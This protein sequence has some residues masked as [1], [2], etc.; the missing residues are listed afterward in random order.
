MNRGTVISGV[1]VLAI[2]A[3]GCQPAESGGR[4]GDAKGALP[5]RTSEITGELLG[6]AEISQRLKET[7]EC[8]E[9]QGLVV[10]YD[11]RGGL[12]S[13]TQ[14]AEQGDLWTSLYGECGEAAGLFDPLT[15]SELGELYRLELENHACLREHGYPS[16]E[17]PT[18]QSFIDRWLAG[19]E[20]YQS[21]AIVADHPDPE[22][23][24]DATQLC[25]APLWSLG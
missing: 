22:V 3:V 15:E 13:E 8:M 6:T 24:F 9:A 12:M 21:I 2:V 25:P 4:S 20:P 11:G 5:Q 19:D 14:T 16:G 7:H 1:C 17:P 18:E 10:E 23:F